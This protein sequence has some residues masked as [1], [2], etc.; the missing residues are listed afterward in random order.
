MDLCDIGRKK[1]IEL[2]S[3]EE[4]LEDLKQGKIVVIMDDENR[5]NEG[6]PSSGTFRR[7]HCAQYGSRDI[8]CRRGAD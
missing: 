3:I 5:E 2:N 4:I 8:S 7:E 1:M 6:H